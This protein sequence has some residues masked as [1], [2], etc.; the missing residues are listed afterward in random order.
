M[1]DV[2]T[3]KLTLAHLEIEKR[4][5]SLTSEQLA[6]VIPTLHWWPAGRLQD[7]FYLAVAERIDPTLDARCR[8]FSE[9]H[10]T[11]G[12][13]AIMVV[14][15]EAILATLIRDVAAATNAQLAGAAWVYSKISVAVRKR[16]DLEMAKR[17]DPTFMERH[18]CTG[19][20]DTDSWPTDFLLRR[21][22]ET[23]RTLGVHLEERALSRRDPTNELRSALDKVDSMFGRAH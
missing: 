21:S 23:I 17:L 6:D 11:T 22:A 15:D 20:T 3:S 12:D 4:I 9:Y 1:T 8:A 2:T 14:W 10:E 16:V 18:R 5:E 13:E 19:A 7:Y